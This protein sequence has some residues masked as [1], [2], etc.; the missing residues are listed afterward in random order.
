MKH[1]NMIFRTLT[2]RRRRRR[3]RHV[4]NQY[5]GAYADPKDYERAKANLENLTDMSQV[6]EVVE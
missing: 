6:V 5:I 3:A 2:V 4:E 1:R